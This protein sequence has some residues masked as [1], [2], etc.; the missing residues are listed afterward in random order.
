[1]GY[2]LYQKMEKD[3]VRDKVDK[4]DNGALG[5][6]EDSTQDREGSESLR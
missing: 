2:K 1:M 4:A 6:I 5:S 3:K